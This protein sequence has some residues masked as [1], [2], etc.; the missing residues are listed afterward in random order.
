MEQGTR[1]VEILK[2]TSIKR[3]VPVYRFF[4]TSFVLRSSRSASIGAKNAEMQFLLQE[5]AKDKRKFELLLNSAV[6]LRWV[7]RGR[8][9][10]VVGLCAWILSAGVTSPCPNIANLCIQTI[11]KLDQNSEHTSLFCLDF[12]FFAEILLDLGAHRNAVSVHDPVCFAMENLKAGYVANAV[13]CI[14]L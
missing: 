2:Q 12:T 11:M 3:T 7:K 5:A 6:L 4:D 8:I 9:T 14:L 10:D 13:H 1:L